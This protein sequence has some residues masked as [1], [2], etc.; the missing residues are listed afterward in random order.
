MSA[1]KNIIK[2]ADEQFINGQIMEQLNLNFLSEK[3]RIE[4]LD[5]MNEVINQRVLLRIFEQVGSRKQ[6]IMTELLDK[7]TDKELEQFIR[8]NAPNFLE[9]LQEEIMNLKKDL[10]AQIGRKK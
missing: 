1:L 3:E 8:D 5:R 10:L 7:G 4:L 2:M 9:I 6:E